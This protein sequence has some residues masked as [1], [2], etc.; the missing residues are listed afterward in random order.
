MKNDL[1]EI[2]ISGPVSIDSDKN[3]FSDGICIQKVH[4]LKVF[5]AGLTDFTI[6]EPDTRKISYDF[7]YNDIFNFCFVSIGD[8]PYF[9]NNSYIASELKKGYRFLAYVDDHY[10]TAFLSNFNDAGPVKIFFKSAHSRVQKNG[11]LILNVK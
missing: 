7:C 1:K 6:P 9:L 11:K 10:L 2:R 8:Y 5:N 4:T 3:C